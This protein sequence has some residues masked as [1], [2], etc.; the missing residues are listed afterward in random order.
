M[1]SDPP[2]PEGRVLST[3]MEDGSR[4]WLHP[5]PA[6]GPYLRARRILAC[7][8]IA[9][10]TLLPYLKIH[11]KPAVLLDL[12]S[13]E[14][15]I[16]GF[17][18][19]STDTLLAGPGADHADLEHL[20]GDGPGGPRVVRLDVPADGLHGVRFP[21]H[22]AA[23]RRPARGP[24][25]PGAEADDA[26]DGGEICPVP[27]DFRLSG[28]HL[29]GLLC[30]RR[31]PGPVGPPFAAGASGV[32]PGDARG[33]RPDDVRFR[34]LPR[35]GLHRGLSLRAVPVGDARSRLADRE[36]RSAPRR[37][38]RQTGRPQARFVARR[39]HRLRPVQRHLPH[40]HRYSRRAAT[41]VHRLHAVHRRLQRRDGADR[42]AQ[43]AD[44]AEFAGRHRRQPRRGCCGCAWSSI[45]P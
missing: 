41:G 44:P 40:G 27:G 37:T 20:P 26:A 28:P 32:V 33:D 35:A 34:L 11:G 29:P 24:A 31:G 12:P 18:F 25:S 23:V 13:R 2:L 5:R 14:F 21:A 1:T 45:R 15:T 39:L 42:Q 4:R 43:G 22:R 17:T 36:L 30:R 16:F 19:L 3:L 8:L 9:V 6:S 10:F 7:V 38:A